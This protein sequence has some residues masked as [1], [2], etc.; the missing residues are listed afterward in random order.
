MLD[1]I[2]T[3]L[4]LSKVPTT[5]S[6]EYA[7][8]NEDIVD[9]RPCQRYRTRTPWWWPSLALSFGLG[10]LLT[11]ALGSMVNSSVFMRTPAATRRFPEVRPGFDD[12]TG[13]PLHWY[14]GDCGNSAA[15]ARALGCHFDS[16]IHAWLPKD[17]VTEEDIEDERLMYQDRDWPYEVD[18]RNL[19]LQEVQAGDYHNIT[20]TFDMH[21]THCMYALKRMHRVML[22]ATQKMDSY[23][24]NF[25][26]T[27][28]C[29]DL[30]RHLPGEMEGEGAGHKLFVKYPI[31]L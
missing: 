22:D 9:Q 25:N 21:M 27:T 14:N 30:L 28:H 20:T 4:R 1:Q 6:Q 19:T 10:A 15:E 8:L 18:G 24:V 7:L 5:T 31:C 11:L 2:K 17:C 29:V 3:S 12:K 16:A 23:T 26:H 13:L